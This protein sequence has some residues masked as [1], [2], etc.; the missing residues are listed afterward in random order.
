M[1]HETAARTIRTSPIM[2]SEPCLVQTS[3]PRMA[4]R[5]SIPVASPVIFAE[6]S[7]SPNNRTASRLEY[8]GMEYSSTDDL[9]ASTKRRPYMTSKNTT[10]VCRIPTMIRCFHV[11]FGGSPVF[12]VQTTNSM[13]MDPV[14]NRK[15]EKVKGPMKAMASFMSTQAYP[16]KRVMVKMAIQSAHL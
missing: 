5:P 1:P 2:I 16:H 3:H 11:C 10:D 6:V 13:V 15:A 7:R 4:I 12:S 8:M 9:P 14:P